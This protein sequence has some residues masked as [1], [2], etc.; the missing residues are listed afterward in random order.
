MPANQPSSRPRSPRSASA[1][2]EESRRPRGGALSSLASSPVPTSRRSAIRAETASSAAVAAASSSSTAGCG[3]ANG[4]ISSAQPSGVAQRSHSSAAGGVGDDPQREG[5]GEDRHP[6][7]Q[8]Q[9]PGR[10]Q[11]AGE[12][13]DADEDRR[14]RGDLQRQV[15]RGA[16]PRARRPAARARSPARSGRRRRRPRRARR[17]GRCGGRSARRGRAP[18][19]PSS[20]SARC[21]RTAAKIPQTAAK[22]ERMPPVRQADVAADGEEVVRHP[23]EEPDRLVVAEARSRTAAARRRSGS[24]VRSRP[25]GP[26]RPARR[27]RRRRACG[28]GRRPRRGARSPWRRRS[29][30][31]A[32]RPATVGAVVVVEEDLLQ[33]GLAAGQRH[34][35]QLGQRRQQR[36]HRAAHLAAQRV[37]AGAHDPHARPAA[38]AAAP[39]PRS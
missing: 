38:A 13:A 25:P 18:Q 22:I 19:R 31:P 28:C 9:P 1:V 16:R 7:P 15:G 2:G 4:R 8:R 34:H 17:G 39:A 11:L 12:R 6:Q 37:L 3:P 5:S 35:R 30:R 24:C 23:V 27:A 26:A 10:R 29:W 33:R 21:A 20:S 32:S 36:P 14:D